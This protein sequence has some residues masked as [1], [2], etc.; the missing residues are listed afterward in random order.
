MYF[1]LCIHIQGL[2]AVLCLVTQLC[3]TLYDPMDCGPPGSSVRGDSPGKNSGVGSMPIQGLNPGLL[4]C[5]QILCQL[6]HKGSSGG[7][8]YAQ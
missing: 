8:G 5:K 1:S 4:H 2:C 7:Q 3:P 6:R